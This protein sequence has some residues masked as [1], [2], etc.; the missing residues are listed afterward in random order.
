MSYSSSQHV[1][2]AARATD[3]LTPAEAVKLIGDPGVTFIDVR[4]P[5]E[6]AKTGSITGAVNAPRA[7]LEF[8]ADPASPMHEPALTSGK[9]LVLFCAS[10]GRAALAAKTLHDIGLHHTAHVS[11]G[12]FAALEQ[13]GAATTKPPAG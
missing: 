5:A 6:L 1:A 9:R 13:A 4:D 8:K 12:G 11:G 3:R 7:L 2:D 10:G